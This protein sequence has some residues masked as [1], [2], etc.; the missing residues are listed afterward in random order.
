MIRE[1]S[2]DSERFA[3]SGRSSE[4]LPSTVNCKQLTE[5]AQPPIRKSQLGA[6]ERTWSRI[7]SR[8]ATV[9]VQSVTLEL[10]VS[11]DCSKAREKALYRSFAR[12]S[13]RAR[14]TVQP[15]HLRQKPT[16][17][18]TSSIYVCHSRRRSVSGGSRSATRYVVHPH[19]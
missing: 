6:S 19:G 1:N 10:H 11:G 18:L 15:L 9:R 16:T 17:S 5:K 3:C 2:P 7:V 4:T 13:L 8:G 12:S 14:H